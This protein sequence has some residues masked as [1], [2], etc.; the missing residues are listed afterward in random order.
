MSK[1]NAVK[2]LAR[3]VGASITQTREK[4]G[5]DRRLPGLSDQPPVR[6]A[7]QRSGACSARV[8]ETARSR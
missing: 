8:V 5:N 4:C 3:T 1:P 6:K 2:A 7:F